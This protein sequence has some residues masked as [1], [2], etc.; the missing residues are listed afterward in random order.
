MSQTPPLTPQTTQP[1][2]TPIQR[3]DAPLPIQRPVAPQLPILAPQLPIQRTDAP[4]LPIQRTVASQPPPIQR[5]VD[6]EE[7][8]RRRRLQPT[9][10]PLTESE[11]RRRLQPTVDPEETEMRRRLQRTVP[12]LQEPERPLI[13]P[14]FNNT[15]ELRRALLRFIRQGN[16]DNYDNIGTWNVTNVRSFEYLFLNLIQTDEENAMVA[17]LNSWV[18][19]NVTTTRYMFLN[20]HHFNQPLNQ[21]RFSEHLRTMNSMFVNCSMFNQPLAEWNLSPTTTPNLTR[22]TMMFEGCTSFNQDLSNW[23]LSRARVNR[24][25]S[26]TPMENN[27]NFHPQRHPLPEVQ[28]IPAPQAA[29]SNDDSKEVHAAA[30]EINDEMMTDVS[31]LI[32]QE[33]DKCSL[34]SDH[35]HEFIIDSLRMIISFLPNTSEY[36]EFKVLLRNGLM[37]MQTSLLGFDC[38]ITR[39]KLCLVY[40]VLKYLIAH[41]SIIPPEELKIYLHGAILDSAVSY[42]D[43]SISCLGG[44]YERIY[45][46][47]FHLVQISD[48]LKKNDPKLKIVVLLINVPNEDKLSTRMLLCFKNFGKAFLGEHGFSEDHDINLTDMPPLEVM[49]EWIKRCLKAAYPLPKHNDFIENFVDRTLDNDTMKDYVEEAYTKFNLDRRLNECLAN[50]GQTILPNNTFSPAYDNGMSPNKIPTKEMV[51][52]WLTK[53]L[54]QF[55]PNQNTIIKKFLNEDI[56][57]HHIFVQYTLNNLS[58]RLN[59]CI[60]NFGRKLLPDNTFSQA[61]EK[62]MSENK[63]PSPEIIME[64]LRKCLLRFFPNQNKIV[65]DFLE[66]N[67]REI[68]MD[69][70]LHLRPNTYAEEEKEEH[71]TNE[72]EKEENPEKKNKKGGGKKGLST[73]N[74]KRKTKNVFRGRK[75]KS[76]RKTKKNTR[77]MKK[78]AKRKKQKR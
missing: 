71:F 48:E 6:P 14:T 35:L 64:W 17:G 18:V 50:F 45:L 43:G 40:Y 22:A 21:W 73:K 47:F 63:M 39:Y 68:L 3:T 26:N 10:A 11:M 67:K 19:N 74:H 75:H 13:R 42:A 5:T 78:T 52:Q 7:L 51:N 16:P 59:E 55:F 76:V 56:T 31:K 32:A 36:E 30:S 49:R 44:M 34:P 1:R 37:R 61:I 27:P 25:F 46:S 24:M 15:D 57:Q 62:G 9:H 70:D 58:R 4:Q 23:D 41:H 72:E 38:F 12:S 54:L 29:P 20:C 53:C 2:R 69:I 77:T 66:M 28:E 60:E 33:G 8:E 65:D